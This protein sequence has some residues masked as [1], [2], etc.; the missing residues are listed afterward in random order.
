MSTW[1]CSERG[2][3]LLPEDAKLISVDDHLIEPPDTWTSRLPAKYRNV[4]PRVE[5]R[6][7]GREVWRYEQ[8][9]VPNMPRTARLLPG[10]TEFADTANFDEMRPGCY[11][12]KDRVM[13]MDIDGVWAQLAFPNFA[14]FAG[15][16][17]LP[18]TDPQ[19]SL[20]CI[21]AYNDMLLEE[22]CAAD[23]DRL[24]A[25]MLIP[26]WDVEASVAEIERLSGS[27]VKAVAFSENPTVLG[28]PS[29]HTS[30]WDPVWRAVSEQDLSV[31]MH[32]GSSS[33]QVTSSPDAPIGV[34]FSVVG[35]NSMVAMA[36]WF[37]SGILDRFPNLRVLYSEGGAGWIPYLLEHAQKYV[38]TRGGI[39]SV[40][41]GRTP[42]EYFR[43]NMY[44]CMVTDEFAVKSR[45][46]IG[47]DNLLW[48][49]DY[50]HSDGMYPHSRTNLARVLETVPDDEA[51][52]IAG[53]NARRALRLA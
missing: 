49:G 42:T 50:P 30:H 34:Q 53:E 21:R 5:L 17:F 3:Q 16:R 52:K 29:V 11:Q 14:R 8:Q 18:T 6:D 38:D 43:E 40:G 35:V 51:R 26:L 36:D 41:L 33:K 19:L 24:L 23:P 48:E 25:L 28:L 46:D 15:H 2:G 10:V 44:A 7:D 32:I 45:Y 47:V 39:K 20:L 31:C 4:G 13:D 1:V 27:G 12:A 37:F 22:W 9:V